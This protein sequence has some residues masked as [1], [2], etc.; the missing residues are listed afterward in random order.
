MLS[1]MTH[2][3]ELQALTQ[4]EEEEIDVQGHYRINT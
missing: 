1:I 3:G 2:S 4:S